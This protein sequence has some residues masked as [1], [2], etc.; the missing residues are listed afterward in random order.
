MTGHVRYA[1]SSGAALRLS[2]LLEALHLNLLPRPLAH[3]VLRLSSVAH[4]CAGL[5]QGAHEVREA[6]LESRASLSLQGI[7]WPTVSDRLTVWAAEAALACPTGDATS[8]EAAARLGRLCERLSA[9][10][11]DRRE[12]GSY[13][14]PPWIADAIAEAVVRAVIAGRGMKTRDVTGLRLLDPAVG[15]GAFAVAAVEAVAKIMGEGEEGNAVRRAAAGN[16]LEGY[17]RDPLAVDACRLSLWLATSRPRRYLKLPADAIVA[18]DVTAN[19]PDSQAY[20]I[21]LGNPPWGVK[22]QEARARDLAQLAPEALTGHRDSSIFFLWLAGQATRDDGVVGLLLPDSVLWQTRT[23]GLRRALLERLRPLRVVLLGDRLF[24][25]ATA[26]ACIL[27]L[28]GREI[29]STHYQTADLRGVPRRELPAAVI[30]SGWTNR[31]AEPSR[32]PHHSLLVPPPWLRRLQR[33]LQSQ[34]PTLADLADSFSLHDV[35]INYP[36]AELGRAILYDGPRQDSRDRPLVRGRDFG[37]LGP[38]GQSAWLRHDW[39]HRVPADAGVAVREEVYRRKPKLLLRQ[40]G[41]RPVASL[42]TYG[43]WFGRSVIAITAQD[44]SS[45]LW[46]GAVL[47]SSTFAALYRAVTP[48]SKRPFAQVKVAKLKSIPLPRTQ[49]GAL[50]RLAAQALGEKDETRRREQLGLIDDEV[51]AAYGLTDAEW[52]RIRATV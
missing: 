40:T 44:E 16:C 35:G 9:R 19:P 10:G 21:V 29:A 38:V 41:D 11:R 5:V 39:R 45:L 2:F 50:A 36:R 33:R 48:E 37:A 25:G 3:A 30:Q 13:Y 42:D 52:R 20:D 12:S 18:R 17:D 46:L 43:A 6:F 24:P 28:C 15:A 1:R 8:R 51:A 26:P 32:T 34:H 31:T 7:D 22:L 23:E 49:G 47:N 4:D 14:T 27:S